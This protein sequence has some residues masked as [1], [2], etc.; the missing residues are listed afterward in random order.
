MKH[1]FFAMLSRMK[2]IPR[3][4]LMRNERQEN[5]A[6]HTTDVAFLAHALAEITNRRFG[7]SVD[8][9]KCVM[10]ALYHDVPEIITGDMPTPV[11]YHDDEIREAF[12]KVEYGAAKRI[13]KQLP[14]DLKPAY[15]PYLLPEDCL[16]KRLCKAADKLSALIK[17]IEEEQSGN[18]EFSK[19]KESTE[20][21]LCEM[22]LPA[23]SVF[24][25][26]FLPSYS[27]TLDEQE[28]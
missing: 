11:K 19:A 21:A 24:M 28:E 2:Y 1:S 26:E 13:L 12:K 22:D 14:E 25:R 17:C 5:I 15:E 9:E 27:L 4:A 16:E 8:V 23:V 20:K 7:G 10:L 6:E 18:I 3:W